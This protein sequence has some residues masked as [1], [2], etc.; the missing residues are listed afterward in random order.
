MLYSA[1]NGSR[2]S[3]DIAVAMDKS[4]PQR[5]VA[6]RVTMLSWLFAAK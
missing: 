6:H 5:R 3:F 4:R 1:I 2:V